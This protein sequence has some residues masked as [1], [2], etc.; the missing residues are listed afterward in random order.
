M[1]KSFLKRVAAA[2]VAV[3]VALTQTALFTSFAQGETTTQATSSKTI[4]MDK[5]LEVKADAQLHTVS[6]FKTLSATKLTKFSA[7]ELMGENT[8]VQLSEWGYDASL[9]LT[10]MYGTYDLPKEKLAEA[11]KDKNGA[12]FDLIKNAIADKNTNVVANVS[13][14][15]VE[16]T[17]EFDYAYGQDLANM[18][19]EAMNKKIAAKYDD[20]TVT[21]VPTALKD[22]KLKGKVVL[23]A[24]TKKI[25]DKTVK[26]TASVE[27]NDAKQEGAEAV[28]KFF[29][30]EAKKA[31][32]HLEAD[33]GAAVEKAIKDNQGILDDAKIKL[34]EADAKKDAAQ[35][36]FDDAD[37]KFKESD[38]KLTKA[39]A[40]LAQAKK[41]GVTG[42]ALEDKETEVKNARAD[43]NAKLAEYNAKKTDFEQKKVELA[44]AHKKVDDAQ[45]ALDD[46]SATAHENLAAYASDLLKKVTDYQAKVDNK[47]GKSGS[48]EIKSAK[49]ADALLAAVDNKFSKAP[50]S[51][52]A[53]ESNKYYTKVAKAFDAAIRI[54]NE[55]A[56]AK[57][58]QVA[59]TSGSVMDVIKGASNISAYADVNA[60]VNEY[61]ANGETLFYV[62]DDLTEAEKKSIINNLNNSKELLTANKKVNEDNFYTVKIVEV[63]GALDAGTKFEGDVTV[64][65]Y[66]VINFMTEDKETTTTT[67][68]TTMPTTT[69]TT[70]STETSV[71]T[72]TTKA[73]EPTESTKATE[74]TETSKPVETTT[75]TETVKPTES[76]ETTTTKHTKVAGEIEMNVTVKTE[77]A[78][79]GGFYFDIDKNA[80][81]ADSLADL[82]SESPEMEG[83]VAADKF[84]VGDATKDLT[85][86]ELYAANKEEDA[87][88]VKALQLYYNG[89]K[90]VNKDR[91]PVTMTVYVGV[92]GDLTQDGSC[93]AKDAN[94]ALIHAA[95]VGTTK[96][97]EKLPTISDLNEVKTPAAADKD[98]FDKFLIFLGDIDTESVKGE[99]PKEKIA[100]NAKD[101]NAMLRYAAAVGTNKKEGEEGHKTVVELWTDVIGTENAPVYFAGLA[102]R[103]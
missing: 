66:R 68:T 33:A 57:G 59:I 51:V 20:V 1:K 103:S 13:S 35:T 12:K 9:A 26:F 60:K 45:K 86:A 22:D 58:G 19:T 44:D 34:N 55:Q 41:D 56:A 92:K 32:E 95:S 40:D 62:T 27:M 30:D 75:T 79:G 37:K 71:S 17:I 81:R 2:A 97:G 7:D 87:Y 49:D 52:A 38:E 84:T 93:N 80:F 61:K 36:K 16:I 21:V 53:V 100:V 10:N 76:T 23:T 72:E 46:A 74:T 43:Y 70:E 4:S 29:A 25:M 3:P 88:V 42:K 39:E 31:L 6:E 73:T 101:A 77:L 96:E 98:T 65:V 5:L 89:L 78:A 94:R 91:K 24:D 18:A 8:Y 11:L 48:F 64:E 67:T 63:Q 99:M 102:K 69:T 47:K 83:A 85:P 14:S 15:K 90:V 54:V 50:A 28:E 82:P